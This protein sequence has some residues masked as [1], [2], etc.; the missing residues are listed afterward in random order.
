MLRRLLRTDND[1]AALIMRLV[2]GLVF[3]PHGAQ[4]VLGWWGGYGASATIQGLAKMGLPPWLTVLVMAAEFG[5]SLL[6]IVGFLTRFAAFSIGAVMA[7]ALLMVHA[8]VGFFMN[9]S[10]A[11]KGEGFEYHLL[12]LGLAIAVMIKAGG[13]LS[14]DRA[15]TPAGL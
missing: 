1:P 7:A 3:V 13:P 8:K 11:Q 6:L 2:L 4:K 10:G 5:G 12:S 15:P 9:W 14:G